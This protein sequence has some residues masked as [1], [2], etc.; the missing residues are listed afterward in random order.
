[1]LNKGGFLRMKSKKKGILIAVAALIIVAACL[2]PLPEGLTRQGMQAW[3]VVLAAI[4][5]WVGEAVIKFT[6]SIF[7]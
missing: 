5:L 7:N 1:M 4:V 3:G 2:L 6:V